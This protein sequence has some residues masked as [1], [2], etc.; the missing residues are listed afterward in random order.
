MANSKI[1]TL[2]IDGDI[3]LFRFAFRHQTEITWCNDITSISLDENRA[4]QDID[5]FIRSL[6]AKTGCEDYLLCITNEINFRY[7]VLPTYKQNRSEKKTPELLGILKEYMLNTYPCRSQKYLEAD[8]LMGILGTSVP[9]K[10]VLTTIDKDFESLPV[11][12]FNWNKD[13]KPRTISKLKADKN[14]HLQWLMGDAC[15]GFHGCRGIGPKKAMKI[16]GERKPNEW[17]AAVVE[18]YAD[19]CYTWD[20]ILQQARVARILRHED[21]DFKKNEVILWSP[22]C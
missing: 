17:S 22:N 13:K 21:F 9:N 8:D 11:T 15:D 19:R 2:L 4:K 16:L 1:K 3:I 20:E 18:T 5:V 7:S 14:F 10:Y 6:L 12:L